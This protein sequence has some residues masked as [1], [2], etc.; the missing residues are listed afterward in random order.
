MVQRVLPIAL[1]GASLLAQGDP[2]VLAEGNAANALTL[3]VRDLAN[4]GHP[5][6]VVRTDVEVLPV[7]ITLRTLQASLRA[8]LSR[9]V[10]RAGFQRVELPGNGRLLR[11]R[12]RDGALYGFLWIRHDGRPQVLL[13]L[14]GIGAAGTGD[15]FADRFA[16][17]ADGRHAA[18]LTQGNTLYLARLDGGIFASTGTPVRAVA[19]AAT[20]GRIGVAAGASHLFFVTL[21]DRF[22]RVAWADGA[23]PEDLTPAG[24]ALSILKEEFALANDGHTAVFL[25]GPKLQQRLYLVRSTGPAAVLPPPASKYEEPGYLPEIAGGPRLLLNDDATRLLYTDSIRREE[26]YLADLTGQTATV[27]LTS[28]NNFVPYIGIGVLP[29]FAAKSLVLAIGDQAGFDWYQADT[30]KALVTNLS[31]SPN[32]LVRPYGP[33]QLFPDAAFPTA[34]GQLW[35]REPTGTGHRLRAIDPAT[36]TTRIDV[37]DLRGLPLLGDSVGGTPDLMVPAFAADRL[38]DGALG[39]TLLA[40]VPG[41][42]F[43]N[44]VRSSA[45]DT[46]LAVD[47]F[48][49]TRVALFRA[50][51]GMLV[52]LPPDPNLR[53]LA[54]TPGDGIVILGGV[55]LTWRPG[56]AAQVASLPAP[57]VLLLSGIGA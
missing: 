13:E 47:V 6:T 20:V 55:L 33:G 31:L 35:V 30:G 49:V 23:A 32:N 14:P 7:E 27:Q 5:G 41:I 48:G 40:T 24:P 22:W 1:L 39:H 15:P 9:R 25:Y 54:R 17:A 10:E 18:F 52:P 56:I 4:P 21:D 8:D 46:L 45:G 38:V 37:P 36:G 11:Y 28:D 3:R 34:F 44:P 12:I 51:N 29:G 53:Q 26:I 16:V 43:G 19:P 57:L 50:A 42:L 2:V